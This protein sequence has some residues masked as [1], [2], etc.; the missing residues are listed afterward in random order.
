MFAVG[1]QAYAQEPAP[2]VP[3]TPQMTLEGSLCGRNAGTIT[4]RVYQEGDVTTLEFSRDGDVYGY[5]VRMR[6]EDGILTQYSLADFDDDG[7]YE[8]VDAEDML[9][10]RN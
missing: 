10:P 3:E 6:G 7:Q 8:R 1:S 2:G 4:E 5:T 9:C